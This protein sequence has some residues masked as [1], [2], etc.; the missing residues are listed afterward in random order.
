M[1]VWNIQG[2]VE[3]ALTDKEIETHPYSAVATNRTAE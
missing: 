3:I 1:C 2:R